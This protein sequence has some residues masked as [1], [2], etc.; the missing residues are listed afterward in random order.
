M[1]LGQA[2][3]EAAFKQLHAMVSGKNPAEPDE[4]GLTFLQNFAADYD[5]MEAFTQVKDRFENTELLPGIM[6]LCASSNR[7]VMLAAL[8]LLMLYSRTE[9]VQKAMSKSDIL[10]PLLNTM[11]TQ[12][13]D[14]EVQEEGCR[15]LV[16]LSTYG[17]RDR[18]FLC[19]RAVIEARSCGG[20][21]QTRIAACSPRRAPLMWCSMASE[22]AARAKRFSS[23]RA[24]QRAIWPSMTPIRR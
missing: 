22:M 12:S 15:L 11:R 24:G 10:G 14:L 16:N 21:W 1:P 20:D 6:R 4:A 18:P 23:P 8:R 13:A 19:T 2:D 3:D 5:D 17:T 7:A 9:A